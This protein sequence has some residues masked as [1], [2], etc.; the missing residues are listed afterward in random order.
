VKLTPQEGPPLSIDYLLEQVIENDCG[1]GDLSAYV[2][3]GEVA[4]AL[5]STAVW[6]PITHLRGSVHKPTVAE[7]SFDVVVSDCA[8][9]VLDEKDKVQLIRELFRVLKSGGRLAL[10]DIVAGAPV[11]GRLKGAPDSW[12][13]FIAGAF[14]E[15]EFVKAFADAGF[16]AVRI[17]R[18]AQSV[19][20][21]VE[22]IE[23]RSVTVTAVKSA[24]RASGR[25]G[26]MVIYR[27]PYAEVR[28][29]ENRVY[30]R[31]ERVEVCEHTFRRLAAGPCK[32]DFIALAAPPC[33]SRRAPR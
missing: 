11:P 2:R 5:C 28:D 17:E 16:E 30:P 4:L 1:C 13:G 31:G 18:W 32:D 27:G 7:G 33:S 12:S 3:P 8:L 24:R 9:K 26:H 14:V 20:R 15:A 23:F 10:S 21:V 6:D 19:W 29:D 25:R 22:G